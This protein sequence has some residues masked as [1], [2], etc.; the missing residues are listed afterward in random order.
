MLVDMQKLALQSLRLEEN[1]LN[2]FVTPFSLLQMQLWSNILF[3]FDIIGL[4]FLQGEQ[5]YL[6]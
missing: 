1:K 4:Y 5:A 2:G 3:Q 6:H